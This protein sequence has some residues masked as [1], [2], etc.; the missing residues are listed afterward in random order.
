MFGGLVRMFLRA[1]L[2]LSTGLRW[3]MTSFP[4]LAYRWTQLKP[5]LS[6][7]MGGFSDFFAT[8]GYAAHHGLC[9]SN[10]LL[11]KRCAKS[12]GKP[13]IRPPLLPHFLTDL[14]ETQSQERYLRYDPAC[15]IWLMW[16]D[17]KGVCKNGKFWL[18]FGSFL[19][20]SPCV[21]ITP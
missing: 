5:F 11:Y 3:R 4:E 17:R 8:S 19:Y 21:Q 9:D 20:Y 16:D 13:K 18:T 6:L 7:R 14:S 1:P 15:K 12:M 2:W 10:K